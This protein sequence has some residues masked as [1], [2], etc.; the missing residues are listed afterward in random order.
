MTPTDSRLRSSDGEGQF[1]LKVK[2]KAVSKKKIAVDLGSDEDGELIPIAV[3]PGSLI[4]LTIKQAKGSTADP[5]FE[6]LLPDGS[7]P[8]DLPEPG[9]GEKKHKVRKFVVDFFGDVQVRLLNAGDEGGVRGAI[10]VK[11]AAASRTKIELT[12]AAIGAGAEDGFVRGAVFGPEGG[13]VSADAPEAGA[14]AG[15]GVAVPVGALSVPTAVLVGTAPRLQNPAP[16]LRGSGP[17]VFFGPDGLSFEEPVEITVPFFRTGF[18]GDVNDVQV[19]TRDARGR[20]TL[21]PG[22]YEV[23]AGAGTVSAVVDHFSSFRVFLPA[24]AP[25]FDLNDDG[26]DDFVIATPLADAF[27]GRVLVLFGPIPEGELGTETVDLT[28]DGTGP[29][30]EDGE[31]FG[32][33]VQT[34]EVS[35]DGIPDL[36]VGDLNGF[37]IFRG[38]SSFDPA[39]ASDAD[40]TIDGGDPMPLLVADINGDDRPDLIKRDPFSVRILH[41]SPDTIVNGGFPADFTSPDVELTFPSRA[42]YE[43]IATGDVN[44]D[45]IDDI[46]VGSD[47]AADLDG[48]IYVYLGDPGLSS[49]DTPTFTISAPE[50]LDLFGTTVLVGDVSG[51]GVDDIVAHYTNIGATEECGVYMLAGGS[52]LGSGPATAFGF[53]VRTNVHTPVLLADIGTGRMS[54]LEY[55]Q[56]EVRAYSAVVRTPESLPLGDQDLAWRLPSASS[57]INSLS[58]PRIVRGR[59]LTFVGSAGEITGTFPDVLVPPGLIYGFAPPSGDPARDDRIVTTIAGRA[60]EY[61]GAV[62]D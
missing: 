7:E 29:A 5:Y 18:S 52:Q 31:S 20:V 24:P 3:E 34:T 16:D 41:G 4:T 1:Q 47:E 8:I 35:G 6:A 38:S 44:G 19:F 56:S 51:D 37:H 17:T 21:V 2:W 25:Q 9:D 36:M 62:S 60:G 39:S 50:P 57:N 49:G 55:V 32:R 46:V 45:T 23:D 43:S 53:K 48:E 15:A 14:I 54:V 13:V 28:I 27:R 10:S 30:G 59:P 11:R 58:R 22:P 33:S 61:I 40:I 12:D 42:R 26:F